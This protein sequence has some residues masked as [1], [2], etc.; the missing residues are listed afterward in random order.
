MNESKNF[1]EK[2]KYVC[3]V[4]ACHLIENVKCQTMDVSYANIILLFSDSKHYETINLYQSGIYSGL[5]SKQVVYGQIFYATNKEGNLNK[6]SGCSPYLNVP[7]STPFI[8]IVDE[9]SCDFD[10][11][12]K[13]AKSSNA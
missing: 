3:L 2:F 7:K 9:T 8:A 6:T 11:K 12:I 5:S 10:T 4:L 1:L 13:I